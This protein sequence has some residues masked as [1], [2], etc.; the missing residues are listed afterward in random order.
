ML[1]VGLVA[2]VHRHVYLCMDNAPQY[3][4][5]EIV[6]EE[7]QVTGTAP[8]QRAGTGSGERRNKEQNRPGRTRP[9]NN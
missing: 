6:G 8:M 5:A 4:G 1:M 2:E 7:M 3:G 9:G